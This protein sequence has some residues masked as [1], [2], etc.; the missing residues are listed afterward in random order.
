MMV[1]PAVPLVLLVVAGVSLAGPGD[2]YTTRFDNI[3]IDTVLK[4]ERLLKKAFQ[5]LMGEGSCSPDVLE[6]KS[7]WFLKVTNGDFFDDRRQ[8]II[9]TR[10]VVQ[11]YIGPSLAVP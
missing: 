6:L 3:D 11:R 2:K 9:N 1:C 5:C 7:K 8:F 10:L 4:N